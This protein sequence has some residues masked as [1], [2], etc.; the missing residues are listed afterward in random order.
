MTYIPV[1]IKRFSL[2]CQPLMET[3]FQATES[4]IF[5]SLALKKKSTLLT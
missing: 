1:A 3:M 2:G 4:A 5:K